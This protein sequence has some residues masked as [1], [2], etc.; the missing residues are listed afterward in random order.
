[1]NKLFG[2]NPRGFAED[3]KK[4]DGFLSNLLSRLERNDIVSVMDVTQKNS[5]RSDC[6]FEINGCAPLERTQKLVALFRELSQSKPNKMKSLAANENVFKNTISLIQAE[7]L[8]AFLKNPHASFLLLP[9]DGSGCENSI[10]IVRAFGPL[11]QNALFVF[12]I[13][14]SEISASTI[15]RLEWLSQKAHLNI[16]EEKSTFPKECCFSGRETEI[17]KAISQGHSNSEISRL[18]NISVHTVNGYVRNIYLKSQTSDRV[19]LSFKA[20]EMGIL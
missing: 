8:H 13:S 10:G 9:A 12:E 18:L 17:V 6:P 19:S 16:C 4:S 2:L 11:F 1:M 7:R 20:L 5:A 15:E 14:I 3:Y